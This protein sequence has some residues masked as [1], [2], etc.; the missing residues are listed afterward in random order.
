MWT[1]FRE[2]TKLQKTKE[3]TN[4]S[5]AVK[6]GFQEIGIIFPLQMVHMY[7]NMLEKLI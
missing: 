2:N 5:F 3:P 7:R 4:N 6:F 1:V